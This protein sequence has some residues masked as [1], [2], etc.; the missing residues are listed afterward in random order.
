MKST[1]GKFRPA[2]GRKYSIYALRGYKKMSNF[3]YIG[4]SVFGT[5]FR[6]SL[7][8]NRVFINPSAGNRVSFKSYEGYST[9]TE[10]DFPLSDK[11]IPQLLY[12]ILRPASI[13]YI[14]IQDKYKSRKYFKNKLILESI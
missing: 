2:N 10:I 11:D 8:D 7:L 13:F 6:F 9:Y 14:D 12:M 5:F 1:I 4:N 3:I